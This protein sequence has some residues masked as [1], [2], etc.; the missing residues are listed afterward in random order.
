MAIELPLYNEKQQTPKSKS[1]S[2]WLK[3]LAGIFAV[4]LLASHCELFKEPQNT[5]AVEYFKANT[6]LS[7]IDS[8][9]KV[10]DYHRAPTYSIYKDSVIEKIMRDESYRNASAA[11]L[12]GAVQIA[13]E[14]YDEAPQVDV[15][16]EYWAKFLEFHTFLEKTFPKA[17]KVLK[18]DTVNT[19]GLVFEW[20]GSDSSLKPLMLTLHQD[21][22]PVQTET[23]DK[24]THPPFEGHFDGEILWG[25][26]SADC[27][28]LLISLLETIEEL[29]DIDFKPKRSIVLAFGADEEISGTITASALGKYLVERYGK[30]SM[31]AV[32]DEGGYP[33]VEREGVYF[34]IP[35][36]GEK[37][38]TD[39]IISLTTPGGHSSVPPDHT[40]IGIMSDLITLF[41]STPF[42]SIYS[43]VNPY[44]K[45][46]QC[47]AAHSSVLDDELKWALLNADTDEEANEISI[48]YIDSSIASRPFIKTTQAIDIIKGGAKSNALPEHVE[49]TVNHRISVESNSAETLNK[50]AERIKQICEKYDLGF[51]MTDSESGDELTIIEPTPNGYFHLRGRYILNPAPVTPIDDKHW[52]VFSGHIRHL[53]EEVA[54]PDQED[55][56]VI[57]AP[58][59][60]TGNTDTKYYWDLTKHIYRFN[61]GAN[62][63][64][65]SNA[66]TVDE[67][68]E[69][70]SH[71]QHIAFYFEYI[72]SVDSLADE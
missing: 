21:V 65:P 7:I 48:K 4:G 30:D 17:H 58:G 40:S 5:K 67:R 12:S 9:C 46:N 27:K 72:Q 56:K 69:F 36:T 37:G 6:P 19:Y 50:D 26:G 22:V 43:N 68:I 34:A 23:L 52:E 35:A 32:I 54:Y 62:L 2:K 14:V 49:I 1:Y 51:V 29:V 66:H 45:Q 70:N 47:L 3:T 15:D 28:N 24:W 59:I 38:Y 42:D 10:Y 31:Y 64:T 71:L 13:T 16:P 20:T 41:E 61:I 53:Y 18:K 57:V 44:F 39:S 8:V 55:F 25:R 60:S 11:K 33:L 63:H